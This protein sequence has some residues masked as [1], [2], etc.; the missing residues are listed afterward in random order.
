MII[1]YVILTSMSTILSGSPEGRVE[2]PSCSC[3]NWISRTRVVR[4]FQFPNQLKKP[5]KPRRAGS[6]LR[7]NKL[8]HS[9]STLSTNHKSEH[10][11]EEPKSY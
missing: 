10:F 7:S 3:G 6:P 8:S 4:E 1:F 9:K 5:R 2:K 11:K